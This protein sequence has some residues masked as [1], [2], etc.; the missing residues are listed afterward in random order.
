MSEGAGFPGVGPGEF[1]SFARLRTLAE[2]TVLRAIAGLP[3]ELR[4]HAERLPVLLED[5]V[6]RDLIDE[7]IEPDVLGVFCGDSL[8]DEATIA[9][10]SIRLFVGSLWEFADRDEAAFLEEV[11]I[12]Y[13]HEFG[14]FLGWE[15]HEMEARGLL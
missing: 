10:R 13:L 9:P 1:M 3:P 12:T 4:V 7:G 8:A 6:G 11:R 15:E 5:W 14:H 2:G